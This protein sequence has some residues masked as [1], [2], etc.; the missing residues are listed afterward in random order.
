MSDTAKELFMGGMVEVARGVGREGG[1][2]SHAGVEWELRME[3]V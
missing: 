2:E 3:R 1:R